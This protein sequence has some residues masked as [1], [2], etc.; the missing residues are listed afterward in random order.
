MMD[1]VSGS[2]PLNVLELSNS[3]SVDSAPPSSKPIAV[4]EVKPDVSVA[5][6]EMAQARMKSMASP[7]DASNS[8][9]QSINTD[10][11]GMDFGV[12]KGGFDWPLNAGS[13]TTAQAAK[14]DSEDAWT[15]K[16]EAVNGLADDV[17]NEAAYIAL[18][19]STVSASN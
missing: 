19:K 2:T 15:A 14:F 1:S 11:G 6:S 18:G 13:E 7:S 8:A 10:N 4:S 17:A 5:I 12:E 3:A 16:G 9:T